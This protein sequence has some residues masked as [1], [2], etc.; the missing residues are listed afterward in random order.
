MNKRKAIFQNGVIECARENTSDHN[1][2]YN[3]SIDCQDYLEKKEQSFRK[4]IVED[5]MK[6]LK[7]LVERQQDEEVRAIYRS[8]PYRLSDCHK[9]FRVDSI[10]WHSIDL[11]ARMKHVERF[12]SYKPTLDDQ[13]DKPK[14]SGRKSN[15]RK[16]TRKPD[17]VSAFDRLDKKKKGNRKSFTFQDS[18]APKKISYELFFRSVIP[19]SVNRC[20]GNRGDKLFAA[21]KEGYLVVKSRGCISFMN[22]QDEMELKYCPII[23]KVFLHNVFTVCSFFTIYIVNM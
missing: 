5:V 12:Q 20:Q 17:F 18:N 9:M 15:D 4:G 16:R 19:R 2:F 1:L 8:G 11:E 13:F 14:S 7:S 22:N 6:T 21:D 10:K 23:S 3:I